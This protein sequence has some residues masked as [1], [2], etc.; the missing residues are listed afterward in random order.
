MKNL[1][2]FIL[3]YSNFLL[4]IALE[5]AALVLLMKNNGYQ[6]S[7]WLTSANAVSGQVYSVAEEVGGYLRL[8]SENAALADENA[9]LLAEIQRLENLLEPYA[10]KDSS[11]LYPECA[12]YQY[13][14]KGLRFIPAKVVNTGTGRRHNFVTINK[15][16]RDGVEID[17]GVVDQ[18]GVVGI[19]SS[20]SERFAIVFPLV[21]DQMSLSCR[22]KGTSVVGPLEWD[23]VSSHY[24]TL[25]NIARHA[26]VHVGD[27]VTTSGL[28]T[29]F[30][31]GLLVGVVDE[32]VLKE[33]DA[34]YHIRVRL[35]TN[36]NALGY[37]QIVA[38]EA[39]RE[40]Q[41]LEGY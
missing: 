30:P 17:L 40:Q 7:V 21:N 1:L 11:L 10:E 26:E 35:T 38:N 33:S 24:A 36:F 12:R 16:T 39:L 37:V 6:R 34:Y 22:L 41:E 4:F 29:A 32:A 2:Q 3:K 9:R 28:T 5:I 31:E 20:V 19:V 23:G 8:G 15:G 18:N 13:A 27:T 25:E 14:N